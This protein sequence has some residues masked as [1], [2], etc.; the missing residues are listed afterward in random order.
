MESHTL[1]PFFSESI[2]LLLTLFCMVGSIH[3]YDQSLFP[4]EKVND[5]ISN[6]MLSKELHTQCII[7]KM[8]PQNQLCRCGIYPVLSCKVFQYLISVW[9]CRLVVCHLQKYLLPSL[10]GRGK[11]VGLYLIIT[12]MPARMSLTSEGF[13]GRAVTSKVLRSYWSSALVAF[14]VA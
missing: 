12:V 5:I 13:T 14:Q 6:D 4:R 9:S 3:F 8:L 1:Q 2:F 7:T 11:G 10:T